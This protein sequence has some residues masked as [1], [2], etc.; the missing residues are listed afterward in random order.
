M[1]T[2]IIEEIGISHNGDLNLAKKL[3]DTAVVVGCDAVK[4]QKR[5][6]DKVCTKRNI[7]TVRGR[8]HGRYTTGTERGTGVRQSRVR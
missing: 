4:F 7:W 8:A 6:V 3:I 1:K 5:T 2:L